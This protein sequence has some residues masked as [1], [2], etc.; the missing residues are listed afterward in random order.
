VRKVIHARPISTA[1]RTGYAQWSVVPPLTTDRNL[2]PRRL[3]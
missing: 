2:K 1:T 3:L